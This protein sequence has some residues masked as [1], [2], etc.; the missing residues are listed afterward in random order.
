MLT[1]KASAKINWFLRVLRLRND[2]FHEIQSLIQKITLYDVITFA[3]SK[4][5]ILTTDVRIPTE[6]NLIYKAA[7]CLKSKYGVETGAVIHLDK[8]IPIGA[9]LGGGSSDAAAA[10]RG[11]NEL[12]STGLSISA[13]CEIAEQLGSDVPFFLHGSLSFVH[14]RGEKIINRRAL[15]PVSILL[16]KPFFTVSTAWAY[17]QL[18]ESCE[19]R[20]T[21]L[22]TPNPKLSKLTKNANK[23]NNIE[24]LIQKFERA[25]LSNMPGAVS[26]DLESVAL[27][28]FPVIAEIKD[29]L[30]KQGA[31][32]SLMS[33]SG[34]TVFGV[35]DSFE[36]A[37][38]ASLIFNDFWTAVV[39][40]V[41]D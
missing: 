27:K 22:L 35:F 40:T 28:S 10:L 29:R 12:W 31:I 4:D 21:R 9:G 38:D 41:T 26:N 17:G 13:L 15:K 19:L 39:Q 23:V 14:G 8:N 1:L 36:K 18:R 6:H 37:E 34:P 5:L 25:A 30:F 20:V 7:M 33:G 11:L 24:H 3:P 32:F 16:V 2:G